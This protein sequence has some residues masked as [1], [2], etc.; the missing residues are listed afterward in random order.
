MTQLGRSRR[1]ILI[2]IAIF[3]HQPEIPPFF[4]DHAGRKQLGQLCINLLT[5]ND[6]G[7]GPGVLLLIAGRQDGN[8]DVE[9]EPFGANF[10]RRV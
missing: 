3:L 2:N 8:V 4:L 9:G 7:H 1:D 10:Q 5:Q 6:D